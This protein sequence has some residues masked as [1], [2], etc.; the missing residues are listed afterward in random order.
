MTE[1]ENNQTNDMQRIFQLTDSLAFQ[2]KIDVDRHWH[3]VSR[4]IKHLRYR[5]RTLHFLRNVAAILFIPVVIGGALYVWSGKS[6]PDNTPVEQVT[7]T[8]ACGQIS[9]IVLPDGSEVWLNS[10]SSLTY[11]QRF[12]GERRSVGLVGEAYFAVKTDSRHR[13]DVRVN[14]LIVSA[15]GTEFNINAYP[16]DDSLRIT[17][18]KGHIEIESPTLET[19][20][21]LTP[22]QQFACSTAGKG[23]ACSDVNLYV[24]TAW[25][26]GKLVFRR[27]SMAEIVKQ[28]SRRFNVDIEM[29]DKA[30]YEYNYSATFTTES[31]GEILSLLEK[32]APIRCEITEPEQNHEFAFSKRKIIIKM[33]K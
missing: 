3:T 25:R 18:S 8:S 33:R 7:V 14:E 4:K 29:K 27:T 23:F 6:V 16:G 17:L 30:L 20:L 5:Q 26:E 28:L 21:A 19:P 24:E 15:L 13:F 10:G 9:K 11:P 1:K 22:G 12:T 31:I 2:R 32:S